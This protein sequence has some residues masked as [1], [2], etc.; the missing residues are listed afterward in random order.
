[1]A[2]ATLPR[3]DHDWG[4]Y[5]VTR[6]TATEGHAWAQPL[7]LEV[8]MT[9]ELSQKEY[10]NGRKCM[11]AVALHGGDHDQGALSHKGYKNGRKCM[12]AATLP[13]GD[14]DRGA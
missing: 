7:Y 14:H 6:G 3:G 13:G 2:A 12:A 9:G 1:L 5:L 4:A 11:A 8:T 10:S